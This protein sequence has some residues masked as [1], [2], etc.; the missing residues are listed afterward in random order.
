M[1]FVVGLYVSNS[2][3]PYSAHMPENLQLIQ[4]LFNFIFLPSRE[5]RRVFIRKENMFM[6]FHARIIRNI[7]ILWGANA[8]FFPSMLLWSAGLHIV[9]TGLN[10]K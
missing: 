3:S 6:L 10:W 4:I 8:V 2:K 7:N 5:P 1:V 9:T